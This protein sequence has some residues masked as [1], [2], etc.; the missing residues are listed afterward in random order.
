MNPNETAKENSFLKMRTIL[1]DMEQGKISEESINAYCFSGI[2]KKDQETLEESHYKLYSGKVRECAVKEDAFC[3]IHTDRLSAFDKHITQIPFKGLLLSKINQFWLEKSSY[4][5]PIAKFSSK[6]DRIIKMEKLKVFP[7][8]MVV[9]GYL[10]GSMLRAY[11]KGERTFCHH[12]LGDGLKPW[13]SLGEPIVTPTSK[14]EVGNHDENMTPEEIIKANLCTKEEWYKLEKLALD[15]YS[16][17]KEVYKK[18]G[19]ILVD[20]KYEFA[21]DEEGNIFLVDEL[22]TPDSS[23]L[24]VEES[25]EDCLSKGQSPVMLDKEIIRG[26]LAK[27]G[28]TGEGEIPEVPLKERIRLSKVYL[29]VA[30]KLYGEPLYFKED[31]EEAFIEDLLSH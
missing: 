20:T 11:K 25:Y 17:G 30:E 18:F 8:E 15:L 13:G 29:D 22:H 27:K 6:N 1:E 9:R 4:D 14:A 19:W 23:R 5:F 21:H 7:I 26:Y 24:W 28:F 10:A 3:M 12:T 2:S 31:K 16:F